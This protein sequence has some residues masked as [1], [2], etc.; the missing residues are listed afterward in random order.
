[1]PGVY[2]FRE[3]ILKFCSPVHTLLTVG[4][5]TLRK[6]FIIIFFFPLYACC[7]CERLSQHDT[8]VLHCALAAPT[9]RCCVV[10]F[11]VVRLLWLYMSQSRHLHPCS[12]CDCAG[13]TDSSS[14][15]LQASP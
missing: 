10:E 11:S 15:L 9:A 7:M 4:A 13:A 12:T 8:A 6:T 1:M 5:T 2:R 3:F 14:P